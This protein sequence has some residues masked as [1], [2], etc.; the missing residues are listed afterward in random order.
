M[1]TLEITTDSKICTV[2]RGALMRWYR[3]H[4]R[5]LPWR[6]DRAAKSNPYHILV[7]E[8]M[9]QQTQIATVISYFRRFVE[10]LPTISDLAAADEKVVLRLWQGLGYYRRA[11]HLHAAAR[12]I[13]SHFEGQV[14]KKVEDL[15]RLP[16]IGRYTAGAIASIAFDRPS[17]ILDGNVARVLAR[18]FAI[19]ESIDEA[20]CRNR[21]W[22]LAQSQVPSS[23]PGQFNQALME[24]GALVCVSRQPACGQCPVKR[25]CAAHCTGRTE[26]LPK[27]RPRRPPRTVTHHIVAVHRGSKYLF[28]RR[29]D[30]GLWSNMWQ[31]PAAEYL[32][33]RVSV[34]RLGIWITERFGLEVA[35]PI[36]VG[37]FRHQITHRIIHFRLWQSAVRSGRL[38]QRAGQ[39]RRLDEVHDLPLANP[40]LR[41][42]AM[43]QR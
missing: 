41:A 38:R 7:S 9:L 25:Y 1:S 18:W 22:D 10:R 6:M 29:K 5:E 17:A 36:V 15:M 43:I 20:A 19:E 21:L 28:E 24:L 32:P 33:A 35:N 26:Q 27:R 37:R 2:R 8:S 30:S 23:M 34:G 42:I 4:Q 13:V 3:S 16:G 11:Q 39:W 31:M 14:P 12:M 40:Q